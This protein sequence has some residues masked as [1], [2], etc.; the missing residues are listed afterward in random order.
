MWGGGQC[1]CGEERDQWTGND[2]RFEVEVTVDGVVE[3][4]E[5]K[6]VRVGFD[7]TTNDVNVNDK[8]DV[9]LRDEGMPMG[10]G[11]GKLVGVDHLGVHG[12]EDHEEVER[13]GDEVRRG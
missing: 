4:R 13:D 10:R 3:L 12:G 9:Q 7:H 11:L 8:R 2:E 6:V 5:F 1:D